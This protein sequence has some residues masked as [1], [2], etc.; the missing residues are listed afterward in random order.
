MCLAVPGQV[1]STAEEFGT[2]MGDVDFGGIR[3]RVCLAYLPETQVGEY[4]IVHVGFAIQRLD[5]ESA[6]ASLA[7]FARLGVLE[8]ELGTPAESESAPGAGA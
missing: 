4:V 3:K 6:R 5:E 7:E 8:A 2:L 1:V